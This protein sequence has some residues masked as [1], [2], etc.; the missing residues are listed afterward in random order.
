MTDKRWKELGE[1]L[2]NYSLGMKKGE[3]LMI[4]MYEVETYPLAL[5]VYEACIKVGGFPQIQFMSEAL[6]HA[7]LKYGSDEQISWVPEIEAYGMEWADCYIGLRGAF[8]MGEC[9]AIP[10]EKL[11]KYQKAMGVISGMRWKNTRWSLVRVPNERFAQQAHVSYEYMMDMFFNACNLDWNEHRAQWQ[12]VANALEKGHHYRIIGKDTDLELDTG[13][14]KWVVSPNTENVPDG[15]M[16]VTPLW[17]TVNGKIYFEFPATIGGK[18]INNLQLTFKDGIVTDVKADNNVDYAWSIIH[19]DDC[20][21]RIGEFAF[22][23]NPF[24]NICTTDI[25]IDEKF[26]GTMHV[27]LGRP[28]NGS[29]YSAIHW[30]IIKDLRKD[31]CVLLDG[32]EIYRDGKFTV[33]T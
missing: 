21:N 15:E 33:E 18:V 25:L 30:D 26:E 16:Y 22:G 27:A 10:A 7:V 2:V 24:I 31:S 13:D 9:Y 5:A 8:N 17:Q 32:K 19:T 11:S 4:A 14:N 28:Y 3:K 23:T 29:Y 1:S 12:K 6:K 20:S